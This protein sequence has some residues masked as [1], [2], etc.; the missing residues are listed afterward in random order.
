MVDFLIG[1][2]TYRMFLP[3]IDIIPTSLAVAYSI[4]KYTIKIDDSPRDILSNPSSVFLFPMASHG[5]QKI[6]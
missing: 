6:Q 1:H 5:K 2:Y 3:A 4:G